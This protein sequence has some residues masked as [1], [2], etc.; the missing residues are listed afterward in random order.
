MR[1]CE[2][3]VKRPLSNS[4]VKVT[5]LASGSWSSLGPIAALISPVSSSCPSGT[6]PRFTVKFWISQ[7]ISTSSVKFCWDT[8]LNILQKTV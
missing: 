1:I 4:Q 2:A 6:Q 3:V 7:K 5:F 8:S